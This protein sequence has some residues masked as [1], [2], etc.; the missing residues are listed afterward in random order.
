MRE[1]VQFWKHL[2]LDCT[3]HCTQI[4]SIFIIFQDNSVTSQV[5]MEEKGT[6]LAFE[7]GL[8]NLLLVFTFVAIAVV[9]IALLSNGLAFLVFYKKPVFRKI[10][11]NR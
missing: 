8:F 5:W 11:S 7:C 2:A 6:S 3:P 10:L 4:R 1:I 9:L